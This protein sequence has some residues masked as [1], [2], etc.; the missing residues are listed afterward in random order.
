MGKH[1]IE[2]A[3]RC[4]QCKVAK[5][6]QGCPVSTP[7]PEVIRMLQDGKIKEAGEKLFSN[8]PLSI[9][10]AMVCPHELQC[11]GSCILGKKGAPVY[12]SA[13]EHY[14]SDYY[15]NVKKSDLPKILIKKWLS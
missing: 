10:C 11:E 4:L 3:K 8:N 15:L 6:Q 5:C 2:E 7:I 13:I 9:I 14:I 12:F 1:V